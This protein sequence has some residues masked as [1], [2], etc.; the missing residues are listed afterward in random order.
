MI[1]VK[2]NDWRLLSFMG[3]VSFKDLDEETKAIL[4]KEFEETYNKYKKLVYFIVVRIIN[5]PNI[6]EEITNDTFLILYQHLNVI[7]DKKKIKSYLSITAKRLTYQYIKKYNAER[8]G[9]VDN[10]NMENYPDETATIREKKRWDT[11]RRVSMVNEIPSSILISIHQNNYPDP[12][13][14]GYQVFY[15]RVPDSEVLANCAHMLLQQSLYPENRRLAAPISEKIY[16]MNHAKCP[17]I[18]V[19]C[20]FLSNPNEAAQLSESTYQR[21][22]AA[23]LFASY[24]QFLSCR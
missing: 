6:A 7:R 21:T 23:I 17:A 24:L 20:G 18:L 1:P 9:L 4:D 19:E 3:F 5:I 10:F 13:P 2:I 14:S 15:N 16:L 12:R 11:T 22:I 8:E